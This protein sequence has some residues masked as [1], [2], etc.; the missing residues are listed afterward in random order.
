MFRTRLVSSDE[1]QVNVSLDLAGE[2]YLGG[3]GRL[4]Q[5]L[6]GELVLTQV[7]ALGLLEL[8]DKVLQDG[9]VEV[10]APQGC[11]PIGGLHLEDAA[12]YLQDRDVE[13]STAQ[14]VDGQDLPVLLLHA[15]SQRCGCGLV[16]D[17]EHVQARDL[18][19]V[20]RGLPLGVVEIRRYSDHCLCHVAPQIALSSLLHLSE[21]KCTDLAGRVLLTLRLDPSVVSGRRLDHLVREV[22]HVLLRSLVVKSSADQSLGGEHRVLWVGDRLALRRD[23][24]QPLAVG[25]EAHHRRRGAHALAILDDFGGAA[26]HDGHARVRGAQVD[27]DH[28]TLRLQAGRRC[29]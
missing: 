9:I 18:A 10:L 12:R 23:A 7:D 15:K 24:D 16:D 5:A 11:V 19:S 27:P 17:S 20:L 29:A 26:L 21:H 6:Q 13:S 1:R 14:I 8:T 25:G 3:L 28:V 22:L 2:F 4:A